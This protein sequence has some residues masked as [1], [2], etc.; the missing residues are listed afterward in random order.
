MITDK[1]IESYW[2]K[3]DWF[4]LK[5]NL[6]SFFGFPFLPFAFI[7]KYWFNVKG[8]LLLND[9][10]DGDFGNFK[11]KLKV[12]RKYKFIKVRWIRKLILAILW[13]FRNHSWNYTRKY[14]PNWK[15]GA[16]SFFMIISTSLTKEQIEKN[17]WT[18]C[19]INGIHGHHYVAAIINGKLECRFS[20]AD[21]KMQRQ[22]GS[23]GNEYRFRFKGIFTIFVNMIRRLL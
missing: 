16:A 20:E 4:I 17:R 18:W 1:E 6:V 5:W 15:D 2:A 9:T 11:W 19:S 8:L 3:Y 10:P 13:W 12:L 21:N 7:L 14:L 22:M 23:G